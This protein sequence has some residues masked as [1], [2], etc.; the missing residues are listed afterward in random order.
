VEA[1]SAAPYNQ[2][3]IGRAGD[4]DRMPGVKVWVWW[5]AVSVVF[6]A[7]LT[8]SD[9]GVARG[10]PAIPSF[11]IWFG[12]AALGFGAAIAATRWLGGLRWMASR[13][14]VTQ[15]LVGGLVGSIAF[16]PMSIGLEALFPAPQDDG[17]DGWLDVLEQHGGLPALIAEWLQVAPAYLACWAILNAPP[18]LA[19]MSPRPAI[20]EPVSR[21]DE[22]GI[23]VGRRQAPESPAPS[24]AHAAG[25]PWP[26]DADAKAVGEANAEAEVSAEASMPLLARIPPAIGTNLVVVQ[27]DLHYLHVRTP[28][29]SA[30]LL[31]TISELESEMGDR[32]LRVHRSFWVALDHVRRVRRSAN[33]W[34]CVM[35]D[36]TKVPVSRR[37]LAAVKERLGV[38][39]VRETPPA[40]E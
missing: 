30:T 31:G 14:P 26:A 2:L 17:I 36:Q 24:P 1:A 16:A 39:F 5:L 29:G 32:G 35:S 8:R 3:L 21:T 38:D 10:L 40:G 13:S 20:L 18:L 22:V 37:R 27:S 9:F 23:D 19:A 4:F 25:P 33:G 6:A 11:G 12:H 7:L 34:H 15:L 28:R